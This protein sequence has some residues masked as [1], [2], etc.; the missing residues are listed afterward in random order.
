MTD[1]RELLKA[2]FG[3]ELPGV[4]VPDTIAPLLDRREH[5]RGNLGWFAGLQ[6]GKWQH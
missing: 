6:D 5:G 3:M 1:G 4:E 2:R